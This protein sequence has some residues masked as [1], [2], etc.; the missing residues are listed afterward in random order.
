MKSAKYPEMSSPVYRSESVSSFEDWLTKFTS[1]LLKIVG[2]GGNEKLGA[3]L[4]EPLTIITT[5]HNGTTT[6]QASGRL[7]RSFK[8][9]ELTLWLFTL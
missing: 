9:L 3:L 2:E 1:L 5:S 6:V 8:I 4:I 7:S